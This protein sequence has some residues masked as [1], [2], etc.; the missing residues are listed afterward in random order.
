MGT[1]EGEDRSI[2]GLPK[3]QSLYGS[4]TD[5]LQNG[6]S[7]AYLLKSLLSL[8]DSLGIAQS[9]LVAVPS[10]SNEGVV[11]LVNKLPKPEGETQ[12]W[13]I[14]ALNFSRSAVK[15]KLEYA[16]LNG[17]AKALWSN[18]QG[19]ISESLSY[20]NES[21]SLELSPLEARLIVMS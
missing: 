12:A 9:E 17:E 8:R 3:A 5:Q 10:V 18:I 4:L 11:I 7:F 6:D 16:D 13:Q 15:Q 19:A 2:Q 21:L 14:S 1:A 20:E